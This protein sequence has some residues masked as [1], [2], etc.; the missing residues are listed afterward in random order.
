MLLHANRF[1]LLGGPERRVRSLAWL[2]YP[3][4]MLQ[5][6]EAQLQELQQAADNGDISA[7]EALAG[8]AERVDARQRDPVHWDAVEACNMACRDLCLGDSGTAA[9]GV[10]VF[11]SIAPESFPDAMMAVSRRMEAEQ[12]QAGVQ[13]GEADAQAGMQGLLQLQ[14][15]SRWVTVL[16]GDELRM[17]RLGLLSCVHAGGRHGSAVHAVL[18]CVLSGCCDVLG[19]SLALQAAGCGP[20][21]LCV[22]CMSHSLLLQHCNAPYIASP[23]CAVCLTQSR[24]PRSHAKHGI[25]GAHKLISPLL[26]SCPATSGTTTWSSGGRA[27][28]ATL[29]AGRR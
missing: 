5:Q 9:A 29:A 8:A 27:S 2:F 16:A 21:R 26:P 11:A 25:A 15:W 28:S 13:A 18:R 4:Q 20:T 19:A 10:A 12:R 22:T 3:Y 23:S 14:L 24:L 17:V 1:R 7:A 6:E